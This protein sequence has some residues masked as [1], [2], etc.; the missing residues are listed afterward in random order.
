MNA[1]KKC[2]EQSSHLVSISD[3]MEQRFLVNRIITV[4]GDIHIG[5]FKCNNIL[6]L[7]QE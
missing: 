3:V 6:H 7:Y 1:R 2:S 4:E 5:E